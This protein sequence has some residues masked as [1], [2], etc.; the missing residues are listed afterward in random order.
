MHAHAARAKALMILDTQTPRR[1]HTV[2]QYERIRLGMDVR[3]KRHV[4]YENGQG[5]VPN[6]PPTRTHTGPVWMRNAGT[7]EQPMAAEAQRETR[8]EVEGEEEGDRGDRTQGSER[9]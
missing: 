6:S 5:A 4:K 9:T 3:H 7:C 2:R 1:N 8:Q